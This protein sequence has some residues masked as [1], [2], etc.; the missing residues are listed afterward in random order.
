MT[1]IH[2]MGGRFGYGAVTPEPE[3]PALEEPWHARALA[4]T[5]AAGALGCWNIDR[6][7]HARERL[8]P[9]EY[10]RFSYFEKWIAA[11]T[12]L[13]VE[14][15][16]LKE[17]DLLQ[18]A[19]DQAPQPLSSR[20]LRADDVNALL[21]RGSP[22]SRDRQ[23]LARFSVGDS[24]RARRLAENR[25]VPGGHTRQPAYAA[26]ACGRVLRLH[27]FHVFPDSNAHGLVE[28]PQPLYA[29]AFPAA[30]LWANPEHPRDEVV[31]DLWESYLEPAR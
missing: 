23:G 24:V 6:S 8:H 22:T 26:G 7:R 2:D 31:L 5:L 3:R 18:G 15:E 28:A 10:A 29:V 20:A 21:R 25:L 1:R 4:L 13:L 12:N 27:G 19:G 16:V 11:L 14:T 30:E 17:G 9:R